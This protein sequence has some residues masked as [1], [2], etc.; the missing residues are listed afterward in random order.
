MPD[1]DFATANGHLPNGIEKMNGEENTVLKEWDPRP[2]VRNLYEVCSIEI[3]KLG[4][5]RSRMNPG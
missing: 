1:V 4:E 5:N 2:L 3:Q